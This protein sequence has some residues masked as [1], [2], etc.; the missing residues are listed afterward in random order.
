MSTTATEPSPPRRSPEPF[1][2]TAPVRHGQFYNVE[3]QRML[4][5][6]A[7]DVVPLFRDAAMHAGFGQASAWFT[8]LGARSPAMRLA[9]LPEL[10]H[11]VGLGTLDL[12]EAA[13]DIGVAVVQHSHF[14]SGWTAKGQHA[15]A[16]TCLV[17]AG[18][19]AGAITAARGQVV[20]VEEIDCAA[21]GSSNCRFSVVR[22]SSGQVSPA[23]PHDVPAVDAGVGFTWLPAAFYAA[24]AFGFEREVPRVR[25]P[26]YSGLGRIVLTEVGHRAAFATLGDE[27]AS[28]ANRP[29]EERLSAEEMLSALI[30]KINTYNWGRWEIAALDPGERLSIRIYDS[31]EATAYRELFPLAPAGKCYL[32]QAFVSGMMNLL[33][34]DAKSPPAKKP[35]SLYN[36]LFR[37]PLSFRTVEP[38]CVA[39]GDSYCE[40]IGSELSPGFPSLIDASREV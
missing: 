18:Y 38:R 2:A 3:L 39:Q 26:K 19:L 12:S 30:D 7:V 17:T 35:G 36:R 6:S 10:I 22:D 9:S 1:P 31:Y 20:R 14:A 5:A 28:N 32:A 29:L 16:P 24:V 8:S 25:G 15:H 34:V 21:T 4:E 37:S 27:V 11:R 23:D 33:Y 40:F 13:N